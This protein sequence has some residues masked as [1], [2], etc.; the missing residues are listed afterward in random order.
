MRI[1]AYMTQMLARDKIFNPQAKLPETE[2]EIMRWFGRLT[3][4]LSPENL[5]C[6]GELS[7]SAVAKKLSGLK[8]VW[9]YLEAKLGRSMTEAQVYA[10]EMSQEPGQQEADEP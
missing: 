9:K 1:P 10:R 4:E 5:S 8:Q 2:A 7:R 6:D 3:S